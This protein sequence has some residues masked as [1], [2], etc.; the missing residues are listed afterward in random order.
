M[1]L[2]SYIS[3][4]LFHIK[5][6]SNNTYGLHCTLTCGNCSNGQQCHH[7]TGICPQGCVQGYDGDTCD[8]SNSF[9]L[10]FEVRNTSLVVCFRFCIYYK[11]SFFSGLKIMYVT[12]NDQVGLACY[13]LLAPLIVSVLCNAWCLMRLVSKV[14]VM[15]IVL[16]SKTNK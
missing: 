13:G 5:G 1:N 10:L 14:I 3:V 8:T 11:L 16:I 6:C 2:N 7:V 12:A 4:C 15:I 9:F